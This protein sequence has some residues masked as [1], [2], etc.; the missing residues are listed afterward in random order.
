MCL[1]LMPGTL[2]EPNATLWPWRLQKVPKKMRRCGPTLCSRRSFVR[3]APL[4]LAEVSV[5]FQ[6]ATSVV[7]SLGNCLRC[8]IFLTVWACA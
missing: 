2:S 8:S 1:C 6:A 5:G 4:Q 3:A 7:E